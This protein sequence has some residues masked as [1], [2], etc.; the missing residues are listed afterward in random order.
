[1]R[2]RKH[3]PSVTLPR[4][5]EDANGGGNFSFRQLASRLALAATSL[6][7]SLA[8]I[9]LAG[10]AAGLWHP[11]RMFRYNPT[12]GYELTANIGDVNA[13]GLRGPPIDWSPRPGV[14]R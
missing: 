14:A 9:E 13:L 7:I 8:A 1:M 4:S 11:S 5:Q 6:L 10:R 12:R 3:A 2:A